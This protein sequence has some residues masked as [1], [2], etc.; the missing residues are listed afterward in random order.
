MWGYSKIRISDYSCVLLYIWSK[1]FCRRIRF[2]GMGWG[3]AD[4]KTSAAS[5]TATAEAAKRHSGHCYRRQWHWTAETHYEALW[6]AYAPYQNT[7]GIGRG[8]GRSGCVCKWFFALRRAFV[9][10]VS[11]I[12]NNTT[13]QI[14][15]KV[16]GVGE[17]LRS[18]ALSL[19]RE[20]CCRLPL[21]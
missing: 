11:E 5:T 18:Q 19:Q 1:P 2:R 8:S 17:S 13:S 20:R 9:N 21:G 15:R 14:W 4:P 12:P 10:F 16:N 3:E 7:S 6:C